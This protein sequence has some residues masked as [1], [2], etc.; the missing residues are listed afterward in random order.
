MMASEIAD[1]RMP[2]TYPRVSSVGTLR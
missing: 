2:I 1:P